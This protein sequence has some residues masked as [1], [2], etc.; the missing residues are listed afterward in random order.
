MPDW[1]REMDED[2][3]RAPRRDLTRAEWERRG[4]AAPPWDR[5]TRREPGAPL[6]Y[7]YDRAY[8]PDATG[9]TERERWQRSDWDAD[10]WRREP[11]EPVREGEGVWDRVKRGLHVGKGP[12]G[13][14]RSD[15]RIHEEVCER[16]A[17][18]PDVDASDIEVAVR[19][20]E[21]T[22]TGTIEDRWMKRRAEDAIEGL[23]GVR[24]VHN[25]VRIMERGAAE[26]AG[27]GLTGTAGG[28]LPPGGLAETAGLGTL[29]GAP[30]GRGQGRSASGT[31]P[32]RKPPRG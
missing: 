27:R 18:H 2:P 8:E 1:N 4:Y 7:D 30:G 24:D 22:L 16:L 5:E 20:G 15:E 29:G 28:T 6:G 31:T 14:R 32:A 10:R 11:Y 23:P 9:Q 3:K 17:Q 21:V 12:K 19:D 25:H 13:Y 26:T